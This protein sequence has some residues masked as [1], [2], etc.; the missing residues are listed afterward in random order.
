MRRVLVCV[1]AAVLASTAC[2]QTSPLC[3]CGSNPPGPPAPRSLKPYTGAPED[4]RPFSK[5]TTPYFEHYQDLVEYNGNRAQRG[6]SLPRGFQ[7]VE[8]IETS[9]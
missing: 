3:S 6:S 8:R 9:A 2:A 1:V 5:F 4:L 7:R